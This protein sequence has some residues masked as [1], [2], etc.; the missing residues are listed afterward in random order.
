MV[1]RDKDID[2]VTVGR[3]GVDLYGEQVGGRLEDMGSFAKYIGGCPTNIAAGTARL[4]LRSALI[5][6]VGDEHMGRF[7]REELVREGVDVSGVQTDPERLT[8]LVVLGIRDRERFPLIFYRENCADA[9]L[10][11]DDIDPDLIAR[12]RAVVVT[13][14]HFAKPQLDAASRRAIQLARDHD[15]TVI[16]DIDYRP[17]LWGLAEHGAGEERFVESASVTQHLQAI[18]ALCD[19][20]VGTEEEIQIAGG[21]SETHAALESLRGV[22]GAL[23]VCKRGPMGCVVFPDAIPENIEQGLQGPGVPVEVFNVLG[24]GDAFMSGFLAGYLRGFA[25][26]TCCRYANAA[27]AL[28]V[29]RHG[30]TPAS[31]SWRELRHFLDHGSPVR[32]LRDD[33]ALEQLHRSTTR[34][35]AWPQ[36]L[37]LAIDHRPQFEE[38]ADANSVDRRRIGAFKLLA[39]EAVRG[40]DD[41]RL[42]LLLD[43]RYGWDALAEAADNGHWLA[44]PIEAPQ[45]RPLTFEGGASVG[46]ILR[47]WPLPQ[48]VKCLVFYH[49][50]DDAELQ[51]QQGEQLRRL[52]EAARASRHELLVEVIASKSDKPVEADTAARAMQAIYDRGIYPDWWKLEAQETAQGWQCIDDTIAA[53]DPDCRGTL[54]LGLDAPIETLAG[55]FAA[56]RQ[57]RTC[58]GFAVGRTIFGEPARAWFAGDIDDAAA[59]DRMA[60]RY[61]ELVHAWDASAPA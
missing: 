17:V 29:S 25:L 54:M 22:T 48:I 1:D 3:A 5:S 9:A 21:A 59:R 30:C 51:N 47:D 32:R 55:H 41:G 24:A 58:R 35:R 34:H 42:G 38:M 61:Q 8:A 6:R 20:V 28:T 10:Q 56:A 4:G 36:V 57:S 18:A 11:P 46:A 44:R 14:T 43:G 2:V 33:R 52:A 60:A 7:V 23:L 13:G 40:N 15:A 12:A 53:N 31:P 49:P 37:A 50:E 19:V 45:S 16:L 26:E 39:L 27:G